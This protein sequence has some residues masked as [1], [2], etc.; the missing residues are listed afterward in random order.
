MKKIFVY[1]PINGVIEAI[2]PAVRIFQTANDFLAANGLPPKFK[3]ELTG[4]QKTITLSEGPYTITVDRLLK[5]VTEADLFIVPALL[6]PSMA[7]AVEANSAA[8]PRL[9]ALH[10]KGTEMASLCLGAFLLA[11]TGVLDGKK[12]ST[13]WAYYNEF[14]Q[15]YPQVTIASGSVITDEAGVYSSGGANSI[16]N[17]LLYLVE[18]YTNREIAILLAKFF[19]ID[20]DRN[21]QNAFSIFKG[22][23][24]H[25]DED[26]IKTQDFIEKNI[27]ERIA[28]DQLASLIAVSRRSF[29]RRFKQ[30]T[31]NT[32]LEYIQRVR[33]EAAKRKFESRRLNINEVMYDVG[34]T[35]TKA[36]RDVFKKVTGLTPIEYRNKYYKPNLDISFTPGY[37]LS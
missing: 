7:T 11:A 26:I 37:G 24:D 27:S 35:D 9:T 3:V 17:L 4:L 20:I 1:V 25:N 19:A 23:K 14:M 31:N 10:A 28:I 22:Q 12:C 32:V 29:E 8:F 13:H 36:F 21:S 18:K 16:W 2:T 6:H 15:L 33:I 5:D 30:A 34:Y